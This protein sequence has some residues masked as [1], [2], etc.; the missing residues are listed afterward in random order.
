MP[1]DVVCAMMTDVR[2]VL[3]KAQSSTDVASGAVTDVRA[4]WAKAL[5]PMD[6]TFG[7]VTDVSEVF[8][9]AS[10][11]SQPNTHTDKQRVSGGK[12]GRAPHAK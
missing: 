12:V 6:V 2:A 10:A 4:V 3:A 11:Q 1:I 5:W 8:L 7:M 9:N